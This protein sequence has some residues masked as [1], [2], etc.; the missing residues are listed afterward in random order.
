[1]TI[2]FMNDVEVT[3]TE[4][5]GVIEVTFERVCEKAVLLLD[6]TILSNIGFDD[7][8]MQYFQNFVIKS[9]EVIRAES[10]GEI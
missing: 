7:A 6:G 10:R 9:A 8:E 5:D 2:N 3:H 4:K 1:M